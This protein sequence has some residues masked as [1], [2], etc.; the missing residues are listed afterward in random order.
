MKETKEKQPTREELVVALAKLRD[1]HAE[2]VAGD[3][4]RR[5]EFAQAFS[6]FK[7]RG[8]YD[9]S[10]ELKTPTWPEIYVQLGRLLAG[11]K[12]LE[13]ITEQESLKLQVRELRNDFQHEML[14]LKAKITP[15]L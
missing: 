1:S 15:S 12:S 6:W 11:Q 8:Q 10:D 14:N 3:E 4:R 13:Y 9:Y 7:K 5:K 2:W